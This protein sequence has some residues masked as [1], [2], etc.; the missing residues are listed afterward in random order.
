MDTPMPFSMAYFDFKLQLDSLISSSNLPPCIIEDLLGMYF[1]AVG[2]IAK[3]QYNDDSLA[4]RK[5]LAA[6]EQPVETGG[7][8]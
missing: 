5:S 8:V 7:D 3:K 1:H 6:A 4:Y 2:E